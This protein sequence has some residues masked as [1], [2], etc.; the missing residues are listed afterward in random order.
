MSVVRVGKK[1]FSPPATIVAI[2]NDKKIGGRVAW[3]AFRELTRPKW[4][5]AFL[6]VVKDATGEERF[7]Y[8]TAVTRL[9]GNKDVW[10]N[11]LPFRDALG[12]NPVTILT[13]SKMVKGNSGWIDNDLGSD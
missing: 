13:F 10:E 8:V 1:D 3:M 6:K 12:G 11:H 2:E 7:T 4:T 9:R 5:E